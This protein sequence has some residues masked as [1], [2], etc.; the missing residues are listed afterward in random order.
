MLFLTKKALSAQKMTVFA[1]LSP[2]ATSLLF[3]SF[4]NIFNMKYTKIAM[5]TLFLA[6]MA[7]TLLFT[8]CKDDEET[9]DE[10]ITKVLITLTG[11]GAVKEFYW[12]DADGDGGNNPV[13]TNLNLTANTTYNATVRV[14]DGDTEI[15]DEITGEKNDHLFTY[16]IA[17][18][19]IT[20]SDRDT[21]DNGKPF[22]R[23]SK[24]TCGAISGGTLNLKLYHEP[25]SKDAPAASDETDFDITFTATLQ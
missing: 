20:V 4:H 6:L 11:G 16:T 17:G 14:F 8:A 21:D 19:N 23:Q 10:N 24:W 22:G 7:Q 25:S 18:A 3:N 12:E 13:I 5:R 2:T 9:A 15:T 1:T